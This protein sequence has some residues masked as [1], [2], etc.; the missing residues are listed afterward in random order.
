[1]KLAKKSKRVAYGAV[2][3]A[4][5]TVI[6][7]GGALIDTLDMS[8]SVI[9]SAFICIGVIEF[10]APFALT[11]WAASSCLSLIL[12]PLNTAGW[13]FLIFCGWYPVFKRGVE[14]IHYVAAWAVK[15]SAFNVS[16]FVFWFITVKLLNIP[17]DVGFAGLIWIFA[18]VLNVAFVL[19][20]LAATRLI[21]LY[22]FRWRSRL[23]FKD[24]IK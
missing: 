11:V 17:F 14:I 6:L 5:I 24:V 9:A 1:M 12:F 7:I 15:L 3:T 22:M 16:C 19:C 20:D 2:F 8:L 18:V 10:G 21:T 23:G 4:L 13:M